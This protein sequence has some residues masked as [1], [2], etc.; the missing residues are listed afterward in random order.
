MKF[1]KNKEEVKPFKPVKQTNCLVNI[2]KILRENE[3]VI[4]S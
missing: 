4:F 3:S 2:V 1:W